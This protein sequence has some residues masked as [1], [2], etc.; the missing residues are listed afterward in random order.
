[1]TQA[2][3]SVKDIDKGSFFGQVDRNPKIG[4][5]GKVTNDVASAYPAYMHE[6]SMEELT[7]DIADRER[8][9]E[10]GKVPPLETEFCK[11]RL[12]DE[13]RR[14]EDI[15]ESIPKLTPQESQEIRE[16]LENLE[17]EIR[18]SNFTR[19]E[20]EKGIADPSLEA[21]RMVYPCITIQNKDL[22]RKCNVKVEGNKTSRDDAT[23]MAKIL[24]WIYTNGER[25]LMAEEWRN[26]HG[27][28]K[29]NMLTVPDLSNITDF[30]KSKKKD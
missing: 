21:N 28:K 11:R 3:M 30:K 15:K 24:T 10:E 22:A 6:K 26:D 12:K 4:K 18:T 7:N 5:D 23:R 1:M 2:T 29:S 20:M 8:R 14:L 19:S 17:A 9:L 16:E 13:K 25:P 27:N